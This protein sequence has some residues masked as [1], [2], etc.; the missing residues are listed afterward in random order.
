M[1]PNAR[2][3][4]R[5]SRSL[6]TSIFPMRHEREGW[7]G[8]FPWLHEDVT[9]TSLDKVHRS[10]N[11]AALCVSCLWTVVGYWA[12]PTPFLWVSRQGGP[13]LSQ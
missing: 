6:R 1:T 11:P 13:M 3:Y 12:R 10:R 8:D 9:A 2:V 4:V 5:L 7:Y